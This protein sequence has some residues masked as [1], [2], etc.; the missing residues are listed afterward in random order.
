MNK[1]TAFGL[2][3]LA[4]LVVL[5]YLG[6]R[7]ISAVLGVIINNPYWVTAVALLAAVSAAVYFSWK[8]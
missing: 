2:I 7:F 5:A 6:I 1:N 8:R 4:L 3:G